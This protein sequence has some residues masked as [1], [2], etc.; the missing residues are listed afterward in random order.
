LWHHR[1]ALADAGVLYP[2]RDE[3][4]QFRAA[5]DV[6]P[7]R[8]QEW[9]VP[10]VK[11]AWPW[12]VEQVRS[13]PRQ[14]IV[15]S[16]LLAPA[17]PDEA[18]D[19]LRALDFA[20]V[21][22]VCTVR[23]LARQI[24]SVWQ[25]N[26]KNRD[27]IA[28]DAFLDDLRS[29]E[30][31][32]TARIFWDYQDLPRVLATWGANLPPE[33]VHVVTVPPPGSPNGVLWQRFAGVVGVDAEKFTANVGLRNGSLGLAETELLRRLNLAL[34]AEF[35][36]PTYANL[37][38]DDLAADLAARAGRGSV[39]L[40]AA[41]H[42]WVHATARRFADEIATRGYHVVGDVADLI[43]VKAEDA[44]RSTRPAQEDL[45]TASVNALAD[46]L[47]RWPPESATGRN[48]DRARHVLTT[49]SG[50][51]EQVMRLRKLYWRTRASLRGRA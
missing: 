38:K 31:T 5:V 29:G 32:E 7:Q 48:V 46:M 21:H 40:P 15:S 34:P 26:V 35:D 39:P 6:H 17:S 41:D 43:P 30:L 11:D 16:E 23:D 22:V 12:L 18:A 45:V 44:P 27:T 28:F 19:V 51:N 25:E 50:R 24:P 13:W 49:L 33:R 1:S 14:S 3:L 47:R 8:Y 2:G 20:E 10:A 9:T 42:E 37:V 4:A 36:W